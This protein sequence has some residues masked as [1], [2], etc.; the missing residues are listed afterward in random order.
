MGATLY[1]LR[2][3]HDHI[4]PSLFDMSDTHIDVVFMEQGTSLTHLG[5][6]E[7]IVGGG[8]MVAHSSRHALTYDD[9][10]EKIFSSEHVV[11]L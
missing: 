1:I 2:Q 10:V 6:K 9:L 8:S 3:Q 7:V 4:S 11:V 5:V